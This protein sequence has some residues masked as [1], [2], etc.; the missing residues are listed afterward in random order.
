MLCKKPIWVKT[1]T[2]PVKCG[3]CMGCRTSLRRLWTHRIMLE[4]LC[5]EHT[6][7]VTLTYDA[8]HYPKNGSIDPSH[9]DKFLSNLRNRGHKIRYYIVA[10]YGD[11]TE[12]AHFHAILFGFQTCFRGRTNH[13]L[14][15][16]CERCQIV[17]DAW[18]KGGVDLGSLSFK[19]ASYCAKYVNK[20]M[21][22]AHD[23]RLNGRHPE[24]SYKS[25]KPG[26]GAVALPQIVASLHDSVTGEV[27]PIPQYLQHG[28]KK[29]PLGRYLTKIL[30]RLHHVDEDAAK[31]ENMAIYQESLLQMQKDSLANPKTYAMGLASYIA[32]KNTNK[33]LSLEQKFNMFKKENL[34]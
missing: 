2:T 22:S 17:K 4:A 23:S 1:S 8:D 12:R 6:A 29:Y 21:T 18:Q 7:F 13:L 27:L 33:I 34:I 28:G 11:K 15:I 32:Y 9:K 30:R 16:C 14:D 31:A 25:L 5:H 10:E 3:R 20:K 24:R 19:S 26:I